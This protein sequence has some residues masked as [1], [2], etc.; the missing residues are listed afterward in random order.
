[1]LLCSSVAGNRKKILLVEDNAD[2]RELLAVIISQLGHEIVVAISGEEGVERACEIQPDLILMDIGLPKLNGSEATL[3]IKHHP[4]TKHIP[5]VIL[6]AL[7]NCPS[8]Q[9]AVES[10]AAEILQKPVTVPRIQELLSKYLFN[11]A[12]TSTKTMTS[13]KICSP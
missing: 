3:R 7:P 13:D 4:E 1:M 2:L 10:G 9:H 5:I 8:T 11:E 6:T 12:D